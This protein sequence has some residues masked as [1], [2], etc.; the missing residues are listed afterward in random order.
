V[1]F[2]YRSIQTITSRKRGGGLV[3]FMCH[4]EPSPENPI[5]EGGP[6]PAQFPE[7]HEA[8]EEA[9]KALAEK[10][11]EKAREILAATGFRTQY[12]EVEYPDSSQNAKSIRSTTI[13]TS[14]SKDELK[15]VVTSTRRV[16]KAKNGEVLPEIITLVVPFR[17]LLLHTLPSGG[18]EI[19]GVKNNRTQEVIASLSAIT[20][21]Q[22]AEQLANQ[23]SRS[24]AGKP[25]ADV[26]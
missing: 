14:K 10:D 17:N 13:E 5:V 7:L 6:D 1:T 23:L 24:L 8:F 16:V 4:G 21:Q 19:I 12:I 26:D 2:R 9:H 3:L 18:W 15:L 20:G 11:W 22:Q 25:Y